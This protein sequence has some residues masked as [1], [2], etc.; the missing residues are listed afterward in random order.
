MYIIRCS[1]NTAKNLKATELESK[2]PTRLTY[3]QSDHRRVENWGFECDH[4]FDSEFSRVQEWFK[5]YLPMNQQE[6]ERAQRDMPNPSASSSEV[7]RFVTDYL[8]KVYAHIKDM[9]GTD[10]VNKRVEFVFSTPTTWSENT[11]AEFQSIVKKMPDL[12][13]R[14][15]TMWKCPSQRLRRS[16]CTQ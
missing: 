4:D 1:L 12:A 16:P 2:V 10:F 9:G 6:F 14:K 15:F 8:Q 13:L 7:K 5:I 11:V 3:T